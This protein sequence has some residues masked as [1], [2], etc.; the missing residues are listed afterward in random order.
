[1]P[2]ANTKSAAISTSSAVTACENL[3]H[4]VRVS[5]ETFDY[6]Y[7]PLHAVVF[8]N[9]SDKDRGGR[10]ERAL[11]IAGYAGTGSQFVCSEYNRESERAFDGSIHLLSPWQSRLASMILEG[12][13]QRA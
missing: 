2:A 10:L 12:L 7:A 11:R 9:V 8:D 13:C 1:M 4:V 6:P 5:L 3:N